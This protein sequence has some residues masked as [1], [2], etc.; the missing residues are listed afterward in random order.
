VQNNIYTI[1]LSNELIQL[2]TDYRCSLY[3]SIIIEK[4]LAKVIG[5]GAFKIWLRME[6]DGEL[7]GIT[8]DTFQS[9]LSKSLITIISS[10]GSGSVDHQSQEA[11]LLLHNQAA[12]S[13]NTTGSPI[14]DGLCPAFNQFT[15]IRIENLPN[16]TAGA[17]NSA[18]SSRLPSNSPYLK[19]LSFEE[20]R[21][22]LLN[23]FHE[24]NHEDDVNLHTIL[25]MLQGKSHK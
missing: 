15:G 7:V 12:A 11:M 5:I 1:Q 4:R 25:V 6:L 19:C 2:F 3:D 9:M 23:H 10:N 21:A 18:N 20:L 14:F 24:W 16:S 22:D 17:S 8:Q 13:A